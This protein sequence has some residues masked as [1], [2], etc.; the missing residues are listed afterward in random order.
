MPNDTFKWPALLTYLSQHNNQINTMSAA[1]SVDSELAALL[2]DELFHSGEDAGQSAPAEAAPA[3]AEE[4]EQ[5]PQQQ[6]SKRLRWSSEQP[7][8]LGELDDEDQAFLDQCAA[9]DEGSQDMD[10]EQ[11]DTDEDADQQEMDPDQLAAEALA[12]GYVCPPHPGYWNDMCIRCGAPR[13]DP[14]PEHLAPKS[15]NRTLTTIKHLHHKKALEV[16]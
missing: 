4:Q 16:R 5:D 11:Q 7:E 10:A 6:P 8:A 14:K 13:P 2:D 15:Q 9:E 1:S 3:A 12:N